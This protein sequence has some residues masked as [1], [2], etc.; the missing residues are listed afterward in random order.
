MSLSDHGSGGSLDLIP[1]SPDEGQEDYGPLL[2][3]IAKKVVERQLTVPALIFLESVK[4]LSFLGNQLLVFLNPLVSLVVTS[5]D[6][7]TFVRMIENR[8]NI[9][10]LLVAIEEENARNAARLRLAKRQRKR[11][12]R[13]LLSRIFRRGKGGAPDAVPED[14]GTY[15]SSSGEHGSEGSTGSI[16]GSTGSSVQTGG[17]GSEG[18]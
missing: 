13:G 16:E 2:Q 8:E 18:S 7:Y 14:G 4:P 5:G 12:S 1:R 17:P 10:K 9:E 3:K 6:Y 15:G 11:S